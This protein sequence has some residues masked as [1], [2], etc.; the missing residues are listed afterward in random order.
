MNSNPPNSLAITAKWTAAARAHESARPD[1]LFSDLWAALL[2]GEEG[3]AW[4]ERQPHDA[5][6]SPILRTRF[7]DDLICQCLQQMGTIHRLSLDSEGTF[8]DPRS[9]SRYQHTIRRLP[10]RKVVF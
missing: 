3:M 5:G 4:L 6:L 10:T 8:D 2:A 7:L 9:S 1:A